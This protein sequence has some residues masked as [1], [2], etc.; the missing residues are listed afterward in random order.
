EKLG[1]AH[2][3]LARWCELFVICP[4][5]A[6]VL[7]KAANGFA[8][9]M[10]TTTILATEAKVIF[11]PA[12]NSAMWA[13]SIVQKNIASLKACGYEFVNPEWGDLATSTEGRGWGRLAAIPAIVDRIE[14][15]LT[16]TTQLA[17]KKVLVTAGPTREPIDPVRFISNHSSGKMGFALARAAKLRGAEV[18]LISGPNN[19]PIPQGVKYV[20]ITTVDELLS[21][22]RKE[23]R[24]ADILLMSAA[25]SDYQAR[26]VATGKIKKRASRI[27]LELKKS[28]DVLAILG[29]EKE[30]CLHVGFALETDNQIANAK[31][32][33]KEK[34][35]DLVVLNDPLEP[36][37]AFGGDTNLVSMIS[38]EGDILKLPQMPKK[39]LANII[40][41]R[42]I[43][44][45]RQRQGR[46]IAI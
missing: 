44:L 41:D 35:L 45:L 22:C 37:A 30:N 2:I 34:N 16:A 23:Y 31:K 4:A 6:D 19:L 42:S 7:A 21:A 38:K 26:E 25:V 5:T 18:V 17:G 28:P 9:D 8:D 1:T 11:C 43:E 36:G 27:T 46:A 3:D 20:E 15:G 12:M 10:I 29:K 33:L 14:R 39:Q 32:K 24:K 40:L 13:K